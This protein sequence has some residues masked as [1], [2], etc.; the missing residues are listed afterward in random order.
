MQNSNFNIFI[1]SFP[2]NMMHLS[3][4]VFFLMILGRRNRKPE[5]DRAESA[6][7]KLKKEVIEF[8]KN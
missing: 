8:T 2:K 7:E 3:F 4:L 1:L 6:G 5:S